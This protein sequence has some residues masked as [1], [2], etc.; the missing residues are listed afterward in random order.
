MKNKLLLSSALVGGMIA[1]SSA[2]AQTSITGSL[3]IHYKAQEYSLSSGQGSRR[4]FGRE[5]QVNVQNKGALNNGLNYAAGFSLEF[6]GNATTANTLGAQTNTR[7]EASSI[8]N[9]NLY[10]DII[11]GSTTFTVGVDHVQNSTMSSVPQ[12]SNIIDNVAVGM[13]SLATNQIGATTKEAM[14]A[15]IVQVIPG[16]GITASAIYAPTGRDFGS[17]DQTINAS[18]SNNSS[19]EVGVVGVNAFGVNGLNFHVFQNAERA[20]GG[21]TGISDLR[22]RTYGVGYTTGA[23]GIG[24]EK[25]YT[26]RATTT[27][28][29]EEDVSAKVYGVTYAVDKNFTLGFSMLKNDK[30]SSSINETI[31]SIQAGYNL[32][33]VAVVG[34]VSKGTD[35][36]Y[37]SG[38][39]IKELA[40]RLS[41]KF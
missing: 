40:V 27:Q 21:T 33:P 28:I 17:T 11:A 24:A 5:S 15:G 16:T 34:Y 39:D 31:K 18:S 25:H 35:V 22:G 20:A 3:D 37:S 14:Y 9:E 38:N 7:T 32:G 10:I 4:G 23:F 41:T 19:Y 30:A 29:G 36:N 1:G 2:I 26:N 8:S 12:V 6:D 13:G